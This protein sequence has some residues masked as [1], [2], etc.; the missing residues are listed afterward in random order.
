MR[1]AACVSVLDKASSPPVPLHLLPFSPFY[2]LLPSAS[3]NLYLLTTPFQ[4]LP[5]SSL[6]SIFFALGVYLVFNNPINHG[7]HI[8]FPGL[9]VIFDV[10]FVNPFLS[11]LFLFT[12]N[13][14]NSI[15]WSHPPTWGG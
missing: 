4:S 7:K 13:Y 10:F 6:P 9:F 14:G 3:F 2:A 15:S 12:Y 11:A 5:S 8:L 1:L